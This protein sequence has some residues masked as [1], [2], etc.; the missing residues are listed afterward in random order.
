MS[1]SELKKHIVTAHPVLVDTGIYSGKT[2]ALYIVRDTKASLCIG[3]KLN[4]TEADIQIRYLG[5]DVCY[6][7]WIPRGSS[8]ILSLE[9][10]LDCLL[11]SYP[12]TIFPRIFKKGGLG[13]LIK[14]DRLSHKDV[15]LLCYL[16]KTYK[17]SE[18]GGPRDD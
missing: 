14:N 9:D 1:F 5:W 16:E 13:A 10:N 17:E 3:M 15:E 11:E 4:E 6:D 18:R 2:P 8:R 12:P 7:E